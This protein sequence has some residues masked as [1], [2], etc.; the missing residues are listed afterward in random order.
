MRKQEHTLTLRVSKEVIQRLRQI[1]R[2][3]HCSVSDVARDI[4]SAATTEDAE[5]IFLDEAAW[6]RAVLTRDEN[7]CA[8][9]GRKED[10]RAYMLVSERN[11]GVQTLSNGITLCFPC[12]R[13]QHG[14]ANEPP[15]HIY[16][17]YDELPQCWLRKYRCAREQG[18]IFWERHLA[19]FLTQRKRPMSPIVEWYAE[20]F[21]RDVPEH[22][23]IR[24][25]IELCPTPDIIARFPSRQYTSMDEVFEPP[26]LIW[27][28]R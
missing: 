23:I 26:P 17:P 7:E 24:T 6:E 2:R 4:L 16:T 10:T 25:L 28:G 18:K 15:Q 27:N 19:C 22:V 5:H 21:L 14:G 11:G 9:C 12:Y 13:Q 3:N 1:A 20:T 8:S